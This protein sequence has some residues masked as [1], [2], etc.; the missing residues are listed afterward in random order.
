WPLN[1]PT[2]GGGREWLACD[3]MAAP[4]AESPMDYRSDTRNRD[5]NPQGLVSSDGPSRMPAP[6]RQRWRKV[7]RGLGVVGLVVAVA[8]AILTRAPHRA[9]K[10]APPSTSSGSPV[11]G[12]LPAE[13]DPSFG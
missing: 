6:T 3:P 4:A 1:E 8:F 12:G 7:A 10:A 2:F 11:G 9:H 5:Q 13:K